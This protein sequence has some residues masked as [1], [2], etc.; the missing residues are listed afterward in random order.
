MDKIINHVGIEVSASIKARETL[1]RKPLLHKDKSSLGIKFVCIYRAAV[2]ML[3]Y[4]QVST[5]P[6]ISMVVHQC[7]HLYN[8]PLPVHERDVRRISKYLAIT[9]TYADLI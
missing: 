5:Q 2:S 7:A 6:K 4:L 9:S 3:S 1:S 8:N